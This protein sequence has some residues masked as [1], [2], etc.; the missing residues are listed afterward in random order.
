MLEWNI[1]LAFAQKTNLCNS[2]KLKGTIKCLNEDQMNQIINEVKGAVSQWKDVAH[3]IG[4]SRSK[5]KYLIF[6]YIILF[7]E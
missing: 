6:E 1:T 7:K 4:I 2:Y 5:I 3:K